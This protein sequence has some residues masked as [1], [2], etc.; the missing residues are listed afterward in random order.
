MNTQGYS[1]HLGVGENSCDICKEISHKIFAFENLILNIFHV[2]AII[3]KLDV[4]LLKI[5]QQRENLV[6]EGAIKIL[7]N[8]TY[9]IPCKNLLDQTN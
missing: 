5:P 1:Y 8:Q 2:K 9:A 7:I 6:W 3:I 4:F